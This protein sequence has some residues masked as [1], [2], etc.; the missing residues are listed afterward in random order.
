[1]PVLKLAKRSVDG[2]KPTDRPFIAFDTELHG[3][4]VRV[5]PSGA[6]TFVFEYRP[7]GGGRAVAKRRLKLGRY[8]PLTVDG[9][10]EKARRAHARVELGADPAAE[11]I[12]QRTALTVG[13]LI[14]AF[15]AEHVEPK[16]KAGTAEAHKVALERLRAAH[17]SIKAESLTRLQVAALHSGLRRHPFAA[18]RFLSV[19][20]KLFNWSGARGLTPG[21]HNP[22]TRIERYK[23]PRRERYLTTEEIGRLGEAMRQAETAGLPWEIDEARPKAKHAAKFPNRR[24][25]LDPHAIAAVRLLVLTGARLREI[26]DAKWEHV[27]FERGVI[28]LKDSKTGAKPVYLSAAAL[29]ILASLPRFE[30]NPYVIPGGKEGAPRA[31]LKKPWAAV[32]KA[33]GLQRLRIHDLRH[34]FASV[35]AGASMGLPI[36]GK[37]LGH[38]QPATTARYAHL[39]ADPMRRAVETIGATIGSALDG[40]GRGD[41]VPMPMRAVRKAAS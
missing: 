29:A 41:V 20:S 17:G 15:I 33:A 8:G 19:V 3:F 10:R 24:R 4:G 32:M 38:S 9:A 11:K 35:G 5:M 27:D 37:L 18:N 7:N 26:L 14:D 31:D 12:E 1:V 13:R 23:E 25:K 22:A 36:I 16:C 30:G 28:N 6:K 2:L 39:D 40:V 21:A 34:S